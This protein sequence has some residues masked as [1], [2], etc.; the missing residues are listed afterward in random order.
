[1]VDLNSQYL[2]YKQELDSAISS[3]LNSSVFIGGE[4]VESFSN[5]LRDYIGV[6]HVI[7]CGNGTDA[8]QLALMALDLPKGSEVITAGFSYAAVAEVC[9]LLGLKPVF[10][11]VDI[12]TFNI[13]PLEIEK[14]ISPLT[15]AIV[16]VHLFGQSCDM[17]VITAI[18]EKHNLFVI[19]DNAQSIGS[20]F[21]FSDGRTMKSGSIGHIST[22]SFFPSKNLGCYGDGGAVLTNNHELAIKIK[23]LA[24]HGQSKKYH[25]DAI[26]INSRLDALQASILKV[27]LSVLDGFIEERRKVA[28]RY[29]SAFEGIESI[30][31]PYK[32]KKSTHVYH[33]YTLQVYGL[34]IMEIRE[35]LNEKGIPSMVYYPMPLYKQKTYRSEL[36]LPVTEALCDSVLSLPMGTDMTDEQ[37]EFITNQF[38]EIINHK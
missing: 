14:Q 28:S 31:I 24:N 19:E 5:Q 21:I 22:T 17:E 32:D 30:R 38:K 20:D 3:V 7:T 23:M 8:L 27:K 33:Q 15:K 37:I 18:A 29:N 2:R 16:P 35:K 36:H 25:H 6:N 13:N 1:M 12:N 34:N 11:D 4:E 9:M 26:G 10:A